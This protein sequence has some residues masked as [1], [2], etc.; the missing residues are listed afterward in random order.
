MTVEKLLTLHR[1]GAITRSQL[2]LDL[3]RLITAENVEA[4]LSQVP[5]EFLKRFE[6]WALRTPVTDG[7]IVGNRVSVAE[8]KQIR[9]E[10]AAAI[11]T[12]R[13]WFG[14]S[15]EALRPTGS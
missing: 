8:A 7:L 13:N 1:Q 12:I 2:F 5:P 10:L 9:Q 15:R 6:Q 11:P 14:Q 4:I 3:S